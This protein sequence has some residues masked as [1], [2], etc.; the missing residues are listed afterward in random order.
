MMNT[1]KLFAAAAALVVAGS[2]ATVNASAFAVENNNNT[3]VSEEASEGVVF[4]AESYEDHIKITGYTGSADFAAIPADVNG[5][6][7]T[8]IDSLAADGTIGKIYIPA[9]VNTIA[10]GAFD[11]VTGLSAIEVAAENETFS[12]LNGVL[13]TKDMSKLLLYPYAK[14]DASYIIPEGVSSI[15]DGAFTGCT[16]L[17][18]ITFSSAIIEI[19]ADGFKACRNISKLN[20]PETAVSIDTAALAKVM[21]IAEYNVAENNNNYSSADGVLFNKDATVLI[22]YPAGK[23]NASYSIPDSVSTISENAFAGASLATVNVPDS[24]T[25]IGSGA[26]SNMTSLATAILGSGVSNIG[27]NAFAG[28]SS[29]VSVIIGSAETIGD[30][31][32]LNCKSLKSVSIPANTTDIAATAFDGCAAL[33]DINASSASTVFSSIDGVLFDKN[34]ETLIKYPY[35]RTAEEYTVPDSVVTLADSSFKNCANLASVTLGAS[36]SSFEG[37]VFA[38]CTAL[39]DINVSD[40]NENYSSV[41]GV[42]YSKDGTELVKYPCG[43]ESGEFEIPAGMTS[44]GSGAFA[45]GAAITAFT[46]PEE[47]TAFTAINGV[48]FSKD[49]ASLIKYPM[50][51]EAD[52]YIVAENVA[53]VAENA[54]A[55]VAKLEGIEFASGETAIAPEA[56]S[57]TNNELVFYGTMDSTAK[58]YAELNGYRFIALDG[59]YPFGDVNGDGA[60]DALDASDVLNVYALTSTGHRCRYIEAQ[61]VAADID[62]DGEINSID[63]S[64]ILAYYA[65]AATTE[66]PLSIEDYYYPAEVTTE[67]E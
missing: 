19:T 49:E 65:Y 1:K 34:G 38:G 6:P 31:A 30:N 62:R 57:D 58:V 25:E 67:A 4:S 32:F 36:F 24:V 20:I 55:G 10:D 26:F 18:E 2:A 37:R 47:N 46:V 51:A 15:T 66:D 41:N 28:D 56:F 52:F 40:D 3:A 61:K 33:T 16:A 5:V 44:F 42:L 35:A 53:S 11:K 63:A 54:F 50:A 45:D 64:R 59:N 9:T 48:V 23:T 21:N 17:K 13:F 12:T 39:S 7:V 14:P 43:R 8:E 60:V 29:L 27:S 22:C